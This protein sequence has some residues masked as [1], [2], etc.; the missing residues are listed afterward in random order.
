[1]FTL[2]WYN[3]SIEKTKTAKTAGG[4]TMIY[5]IVDCDYDDM[6]AKPI[7]HRIY[8][9]RA[10]AQKAFEKYKPRA[11]GSDNIKLTLY[12]VDTS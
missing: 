6:Y 3:R 7:F 2:F 10:Y 11:L 12:K 1:M 9:K 8:R 5:Y 4:I